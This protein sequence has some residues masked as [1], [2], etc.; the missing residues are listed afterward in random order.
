MKND[1]FASNNN[2][3]WRTNLSGKEFNKKLKSYE[4]PDSNP[5]DKGE[6]TSGKFDNPKSSTGVKIPATNPATPAST[7]NTTNPIIDNQNI[8]DS[9]NSNSD[10]ISKNNKLMIKVGSTYILT[11]L[12]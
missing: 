9:L 8:N 11:Q 7:S 2:G 5:L 4:N 1:G 12:V 6:S 3:E 10:S